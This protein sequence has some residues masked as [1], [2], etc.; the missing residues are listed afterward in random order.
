M[1]KYT[2]ISQARASLP[3]LVSSVSKKMNR[4]VITV[5]GKP[6]VTVMSTEELESLEETL[7]ILSDKKLMKAIKEGEEDLRKGRYVTLEQLKQEL[8]LDV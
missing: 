4:V 5:K 6:K 1:T 2:T 7:E 8:K 3:S